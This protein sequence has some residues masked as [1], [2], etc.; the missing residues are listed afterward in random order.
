MLSVLYQLEALSPVEWE[1]VVV[2]DERHA[3][4]Q[5]VSDDDMVAG[6]VVLLGLVD[7]EAGIAVVVLLVR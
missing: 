3:V 6:V 4:A 7:F 1:L 5:G 2:A